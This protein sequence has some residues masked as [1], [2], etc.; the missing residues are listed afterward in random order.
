MLSLSK[1]DELKC[2]SGHFFQHPAHVRRPGLDMSGE[3]LGL[4]CSATVERIGAGV[5]DLHPGD[6]VLSPEAAMGWYR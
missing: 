4:E 5:T 1:H 3:L 6:S 2:V